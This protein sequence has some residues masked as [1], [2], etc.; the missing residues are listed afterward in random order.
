[1]SAGSTPPTTF[2]ERFTDQVLAA[3]VEKAL[4][5]ALE[6]ASSGA[7]SADDY[8]AEIS[9]ATHE[10]YAVACALTEEFGE[11][12]VAILTLL[13]VFAPYAYKGPLKK[14]S[15]AAQGEV[16]W[17]GGKPRYATLVLPKANADW[18]GR[19]KHRFHKPE[20][21]A[22]KLT[23]AEGSDSPFLPAIPSAGQGSKSGICEEVLQVAIAWGEP[24]KALLEAAAA[25]GDLLLPWHYCKI[26]YSVDDVANKFPRLAAHA[27][28]VATDTETPASGPQPAHPLMITTDSPLGGKVEDF[29]RPAI[30]NLLAA[31]SSPPAGGSGGSRGAAADAVAFA[32]LAKDLTAT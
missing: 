10:G 11:A 3:D 13:S 28:A 20:K 16:R 6:G 25:E 1:M 15:V 14:R 21:V 4:A 7:L 32:E 18:A 12:G 9:G 17:A 22:D 29:L 8:A 2:Q 5:D 27:A 30:S 26:V 23:A 24:A 19:K 31:P